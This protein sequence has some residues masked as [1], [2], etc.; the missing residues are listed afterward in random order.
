VKILKKFIM[1]ECKYMVMNLKKM[2]NDDSNE[3]HPQ[4]IGSRMY[5]VNTR[6]DSC[7]AVN[8]LIHSMSQLKQTHWT[9][10]KHV[11]IYLRG[12]VIYGMIYA[13]S[14]DLSL[15]GYADWADSIVDQKRTSD[16]C[17]TLVFS[18]IS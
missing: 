5:L 4:L 3:I 14:E 10:T 13:S 8:V 9:T 17:F 6:L 2:N 16:C 15:L 12:T 1:T 18:M 11:L 7:Y